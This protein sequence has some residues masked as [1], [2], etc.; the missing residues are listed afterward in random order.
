M[1]AI[2]PFVLALAGL[3]VAG[4]SHADTPDSFDKNWVT[5]AD[6]AARTKFVAHQATNGRGL[7]LGCVGS[8][9]VVYVRVPGID[10]SDGT[11]RPVEWQ[12]DAS[13]PVKEIWID[14]PENPHGFL[15]NGD[16][17]VALLG[18]LQSAEKFTIWTDATGYA[19]FELSDFSTAVDKARQMCR[20]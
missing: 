2:M 15:V 19:A 8:M 20:V 18:K 1:M 7:V 14:D 9:P 16:G 5:S 6:S 11:P 10:A 12:V 17:A 13:D 3:L 4:C